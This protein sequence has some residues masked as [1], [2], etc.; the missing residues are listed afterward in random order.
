[1]SVCLAIVRRV[2]ALVAFVGLTACASSSRTEPNGRLVDS[3]AEG[4]YTFTANLPDQLLRGTLRIIGDEILL[5]P[6]AGSCRAID[7]DSVAIRFL[8]NGSGRYEQMSIR[9]HRQKPAERSTWAASYRVQ[10]TRENCSEYGVV[11]GQQVCIRSWTEYY[12]TTEGKAGKLM[13]RRAP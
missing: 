10:R 9:I 8:C 11:S 6:A 4:A 13:V 12:D 1:M 3:S 2:L 7:A 5:E